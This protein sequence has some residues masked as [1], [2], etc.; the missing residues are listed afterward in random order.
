LLAKRLDE[1][2]DVQRKAARVVVYSER[3]KLQT[4][5]DQVRT[6]GYAVG[7]QGLVAFVM[8]Q[9]PQNEVVEEALRREVKLVP[10][11][12]IRELVANALI[13]QDFSVCGASV[14]VEVFSNRVEVSNPGEPVVPIERFIDG[15]QSRNER[16][17]SL[18]TKDSPI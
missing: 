5:L 13:Y 2:P 8:S 15:Y 6:K 18:A 3:S 14:M 17:T 16:L 12:A 10:E 4:R 11:I 1:F 7:F 9:L